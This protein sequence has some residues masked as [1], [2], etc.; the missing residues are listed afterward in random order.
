M[1][2]RA[3]AIGAAVLAFIPLVL[4]QIDGDADLDPFFAALVV[5]ALVVAATASPATPRRSGRLL[6]QLV[7]MA[8]LFVAAWAAFLLLQFQVTCGCSMPDPASLPPPRVSA[9]LATA[10]HVLA[11]YGGG[12]LVTLATFGP[13]AQRGRLPVQPDGPGPP[14]A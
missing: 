5:A 4:S 12:V 14:P 9:G 11:T 2:G 10:L 6:G 8:W 1:T 3:L 7:V 13:I